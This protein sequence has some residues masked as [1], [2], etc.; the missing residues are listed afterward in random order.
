M[1]IDIFNNLKLNA[2]KKTKKLSHV[3]F[4]DINTVQIFRFGT[5][6][7]DKIEAD[8]KRK[9]VQ[10]Y[11]FSRTQYELILQG[12][13]D[14]MKTF[15]N[16]ADTNCLDC[17]FNSFGKCYTHKFNQYNGFL[18]MLKKVCRTYNDF[19]KIP[20]FND[21]LK[22]QIINQCDKTY[23]R[24]GT[25]G[26]PSIHPTDLIQSIILVADNWTGYTHQW[27]KKKEL[28]KYF[29][30]S[31]HTILEELTAR[32]EGYRSFVA[33]ETKIDGIVNCPAS[34][35]AGYKST[36][37]KC[38]LCSGTEGKGTKSVFILVH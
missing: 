1:A 27:Q 30:A 16:N 9:I 35:E 4:R 20:T 25:Y 5:T 36:C 15:F 24:F 32:N 11:T 26:E 17:P 18:S 34:K 14:G 21:E 8:K 7:N 31:T 22:E 29:M 2:M 13:N 38:G 6:T 19:Y 33:T 23:V 12:L 10:T 3:I 28:N 37:S